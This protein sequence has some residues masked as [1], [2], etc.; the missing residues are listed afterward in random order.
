MFARM[1]AG[2]L[3]Q[4]EDVPAIWS[5]R[6]SEHELRVQLPRIHRLLKTSYAEDAR[7]SAVWAGTDLHDR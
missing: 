2:T 1:H 4:M 6:L 5:Q 3:R 7:H